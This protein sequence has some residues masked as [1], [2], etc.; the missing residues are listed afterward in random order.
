MAQVHIITMEN[1]FRILQPGMGLA[2]NLVMPIYEDK[3]G[4]FGLAQRVE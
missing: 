3:D 1:P 4:I 2:H